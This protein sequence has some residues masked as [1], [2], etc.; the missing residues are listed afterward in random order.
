M[1][2][3]LSGHYRQRCRGTLEIT[4]IKSYKI[5]HIDSHLLLLLQGVSWLVSFGF[6]I[7][8]KSILQYGNTISVGWLF[9]VQ[10]LFWWLLLLMSGN[11][12][13]R[14]SVAVRLLLLGISVVVVIVRGCGRC[15]IQAMRE[16]AYYLGIWFMYFKHV[17]GALQAL[18]WI[19]MITG[20]DLLL[21]LIVEH[22]I[23]SILGL[24]RFNV[25][26]INAIANR[27]LGST[28]L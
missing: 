15:R 10:K 9:I 2:L 3:Y 22:L 19:V 21:W 1:Y 12:H 7:A 8:C 27:L 13:Y 4:T 23:I 24:E 28:L 6:H 20:L 5:L 16:G 17:G 14:L 26:W 25:D 11:G 18:I